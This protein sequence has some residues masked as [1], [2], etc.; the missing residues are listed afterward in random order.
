MPSPCP[1]TYW[2]NH[3]WAGHLGRRLA[4]GLSWRIDVVAVGPFVIVAA[5]S[6]SPDRSAGRGGAGTEMHKCNLEEPQWHGADLVEVL[7]VLETASSEALRWSFCSRHFVCCEHSWLWRNEPVREHHVACGLGDLVDGPAGVV[8]GIGRFLVTGSS[9][10]FGIPKARM[11]TMI[12]NS[13]NGSRVADSVDDVVGLC[14]SRSLTIPVAAVGYQLIESE[15]RI[16]RHACY[17]PKREPG[18]RNDPRVLAVDGGKSKLNQVAAGRAPT[19]ADIDSGFFPVAV[20]ATTSHRFA[21][22]AGLPKVSEPRPY[23]WK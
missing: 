12:A 21:L 16:H 9:S 13:D 20:K 2:C 17:S 3:L 6:L 5:H 7:R 14:H 23:A 19:L 8:G 18:N 1:G 15:R 4:R 22:H 10:V 11:S